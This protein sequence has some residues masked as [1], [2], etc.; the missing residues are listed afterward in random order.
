MTIRPASAA[1]SARSGVVR[2]PDDGR[3]V[4]QRMREGDHLLVQMGTATRIGAA[5]VAADGDNLVIASPD[6]EG[7]GVE[8]C[9]RESAAD[10]FA[11]SVGALTTS[12]G[13]AEP[14]EPPHRL[15]DDRSPERPTDDEWLDTA[16]SL[17]L[18]DLVRRGSSTELQA[19]LD[20]T[21][22]THVPNWLVECA[23]GARAHLSIMAVV[24]SS[25]RSAVCFQLLESGWGRLQFDND[26]VRFV[27]LSAGAVAERASD[28]VGLLPEPLS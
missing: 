5:V 25:L 9:G 15:T 11:A 3:R 12:A 16:D 28:L 2:A 21:G 8:V 23:W 27:R 19:G 13:V 14:V 10:A 22:L 17:A 18:A 20:A 4:I 6:D 26:Q 1:D 7:L 24:D